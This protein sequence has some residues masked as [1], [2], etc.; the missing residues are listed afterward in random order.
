[1][2]KEKLGNITDKLLSLLPHNYAR[3]KGDSWVGFR[4]SSRAE[5][6]ILDSEEG[7]GRGGMGVP[8]SNM[9]RLVEMFA[10]ELDELEEATDKAYNAIDVDEAE[11]GYLDRIGRNLGQQRGQMNDRQYRLA[12]KAIIQQ[13]FSP[14]D[15][16]RLISYT[17]AALLINE[18]DIRIQEPFWG[19]FQFS[20][21]EAQS[22]TEHRYGFDN[23]ALRETEPEPAHYEIEV[24][25]ETISDRL[26]EAQIYM[27]LMN[28]ISA[29]GVRPVL[30]AEGNFAFSTIEDESLYE[31]EFGFDNGQ[32]GFYYDK[33]E[34]TIIP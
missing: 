10:R 12:I 20:D 7:F 33:E 8:P 27:Q 2:I 19:T 4:F 3:Q 32:L 25:F 5:Q 13:N 1:M 6:S 30:F 26:V 17:V 28:L 29:A 11:G 24:P 31:S 16:D 23:G 9:A 34:V 15:I 14:G 22:M 21:Q 18:E